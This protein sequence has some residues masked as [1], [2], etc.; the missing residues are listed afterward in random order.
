MVKTMQNAA[1]LEQGQQGGQQQWQVASESANEG[2]A[3]DLG[4]SQSVTW[5]A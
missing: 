4:M 5:R 2:H 3:W 1:E